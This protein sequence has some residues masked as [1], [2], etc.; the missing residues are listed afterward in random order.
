MKLDFVLS[1][2]P[3]STLLLVRFRVTLKVGHVLERDRQI[4]VLL[5]VRL[6]RERLDDFILTV[7]GF[8]AQVFLEG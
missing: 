4:A 2:Y 3:R 7:E 8:R 5:H 6:I 1:N